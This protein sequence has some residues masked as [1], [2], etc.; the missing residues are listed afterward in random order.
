MKYIRQIFAKFI[1]FHSFSNYKYHRQIQTNQI[2]FDPNCLEI[3]C[4]HQ[5]I[6]KSIFRKIQRRKS[7]RKFYE[8][9]AFL[10]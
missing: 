6:E 9:F 2:T 5:R 7:I 8:S 3:D 4:L 1:Q 10:Y